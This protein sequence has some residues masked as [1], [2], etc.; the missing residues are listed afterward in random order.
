[1]GS[2]GFL[3]SLRRWLDGEDLLGHAA[4]EAQGRSEAQ[5]RSEWNDFFVLIAREVEAV[6]RREMF[7]PPGSSTYLPAEYIVY[8]SREDD[9][10]W[11]GRKREGLAEGLRN[12][13]VKRARELVGDRILKTDRITITLSADGTL[14]K[15]QVRVQEVW[16]DASPRTEVTPRKSA[17]AA[18]RATTVPQGEEVTE[19]ERT[20]I[21]PRTPRFSLEYRIGTGEPKRFAA[22]RN[23]I[24]VGRGSKDFVLDLRLEGDQEISRRHL[25]L[26]RLA[27][28]R[29]QLE[30]VGQ[31]PIEV[32][33]SEIQ[34]GVIQ[35]IVPGQSI[36]VGRYLLR[37]LPTVAS[38]GKERE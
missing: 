23:R 30:C 38:D 22:Q 19:E 16:D 3:D 10:Q 36:R 5:E 20:M 12:V 31:N 11:Q 35:E 29:Y 26:E 24:E 13:L 8:L 34:P 2:S 9:L 4:G 15:G 25:I 21:L 7:T 6:M 18:V 17:L 37:V 33:G 28:D 1:M 27:P 14:K 32:D